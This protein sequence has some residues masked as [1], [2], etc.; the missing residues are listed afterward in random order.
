MSGSKEDIGEYMSKHRHN[1]D[2]SQIEKHFSEVIQWISDT[3]PIV[4]QEMKGLEWGRLY[5]KYSGK[6]YDSVSVGDR[7]KQLYDDV[8]I[9]NRR[10]IFEFILGGELETKLLD[11]RI[12]EEPMKRS[13]FE[14]QT[15][16]AKKNQTSNC[17]L[18]ALGNEVNRKKIWALSDMDADHIQAWSRGGLTTPENCEMLCKTHNRAKGN[19]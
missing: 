5:E 4:E 10:G 3:F 6:D 15:A 19:R 1:T 7:V 16:E 18:C 2:I 11:I 17:P 12:F 9:K 14:R 13:I 8:S